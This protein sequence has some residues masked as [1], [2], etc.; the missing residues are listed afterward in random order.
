MPRERCLME[1]MV[2]VMDIA[3]LP[4]NEIINILRQG[5]VL[6]LP[7]LEERLRLAQTRLHCFETTY[8][9]T[10]EQLMT[11]GLPDDAGV[12]AHE[13]FIEWEYW[14]DTLQETADIVKNIRKIL[15]KAEEVSELP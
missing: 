3:E 8:A 9:T 14:H 13:D 5:S 1:K 7:Y 6:R 15:E 12:Q 4:A 2:N 11:R 10:F